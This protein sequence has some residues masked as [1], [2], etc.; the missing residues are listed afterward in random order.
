MI[1]ILLLLGLALLI[2][3]GFWVKWVLARHSGHR[4]DFPGT[5]GE[6]AQHLIERFGLEGVRVEATPAGDHYDPDERCVR[7]TEDKLNGKSLTAVV[8]A[9]HEVG[10]A[11]QH[12]R[13]ESSFR[14]RMVLAKLAMIVER[15]APAALLLTPVLVAFNPAMSRVSLVVAIGAALVG[16]LVHLVTLPVELDA[17]FNKALPALRDGE[18]LDKGD[19]VKAG[20]ILRAAAYTYVAG[21][22]MSLLNVARWFR[23]L[24]R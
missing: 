10:H 7:L 5:G 4:E 14:L 21:G 22:L 20:H 13:K 23:Y 16:T 3:P 24:R 1:W 9:A 18:Y 8:V 15:V 19:M 2:V 11:L 6:M 12:H 17:S